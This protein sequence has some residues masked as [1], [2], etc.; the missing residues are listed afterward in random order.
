MQL[1]TGLFL[2]ALFLGISSPTSI[3]QT[4][5]PPP[6]AVGAGGGRSNDGAYYLHDTLGQSAIGAMTAAGELQAAGYWYQVDLLHIGPTSA[7]LIAS[8]AAVVGARGVELNWLVTSADGLQGFN[9]YRSQESEAGYLPLNDRALLPPATTSF[10]DVAVRPGQSYWYRLGAVDRD[11][12]FLSPAQ[13]VVTP[14]RQVELAQN[15]PNP[16]NPTTRIDYYLPA[17]N[18]VVLTV[19]G[20]RGDRIVTLVDEPTRYGLHS[21]TWNGRDASGVTVSSGVYFYRL[22][23]GSTVITKKLV[24]MK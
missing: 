24:V 13:A 10:L 20:V 21:V 7:V 17:D 3:A 8:F 16:F 5:E 22:Q 9:V 19:Y 18:H 14:Q 15:C 6:T 12:E 11:G 4:P 1:H 2:S 23:A